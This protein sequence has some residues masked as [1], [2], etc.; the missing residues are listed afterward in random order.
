MPTF[1]FTD[2]ELNDLTH[3]F[4][5]LD[6][7]SYPFLV[8]RGAAEP[9]ELGRGQEGLRA[10]QVRAVPPPLARGH[11]PPGSRPGRRLAP[12]PPDGLDAAAAR[13]DRRLDPAARRV[14]ARHADADELPEGRRREA[15]LAAGAALSTRRTSRP[16]APSSRGSS[17]AT[18]EAKQFLSSPDAVTRALGDYVWSI[19]VER[20]HG[21]GRV[22]PP[23]PAQSA[24]GFAFAAVSRPGR[25]LARRRSV[26]KPR[27]EKPA[28]G[29]P[30][31]RRRPLLRQPGN[32][33][34][35]PSCCSSG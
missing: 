15:L 23:A 28:V 26:E 7:A 4:A 31:P 27:S 1:G 6:R 14:D 17:E 19:G 24:A 21:A 29:P 32:L 2:A 3:Y 20:R 34:R 18:R 33:A 13:L 12:E 10:A 25:G 16:T 8:A 9:R 11:E 5:S 35:R 22:K 30:R